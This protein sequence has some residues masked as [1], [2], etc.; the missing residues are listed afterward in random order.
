MI[1]PEAQQV[2]HHREPAVCVMRNGRVSPHIISHL[3]E[4]ETLL[5]T[6]E[7]DKSMWSALLFS[8]SD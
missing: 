7:L 6:E 8:T 5:L 2:E 4:C 3:F 1:P